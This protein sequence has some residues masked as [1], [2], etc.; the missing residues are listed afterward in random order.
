[1]FNHLDNVARNARKLAELTKEAVDTVNSLADDIQ[2]EVFKMVVHLP[3]S[4]VST[5]F[6]GVDVLCTILGRKLSR[7][8][9]IDVE[10]LE[11]AVDILN[12]HSSST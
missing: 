6:T 2:A 4:H 3:P 1:M 10:M 9:A 11:L 12:H 5:R 8:D 7:D